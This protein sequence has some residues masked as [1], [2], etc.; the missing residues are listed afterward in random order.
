MIGKVRYKKGLL[1]IAGGEA[2]AKQICEDKFIRSFTLEIKRLW[3]TYLQKHNL[4]HLFTENF[5]AKKS[6]TGEYVFTG[7]SSEYTSNKDQFLLYFKVERQ[8]LEVM[9]SYMESK[10]ANLFLEHDGFRS[11]YQLN[12]AEIKELEDL[13]FS[14]TSVQVKLEENKQEQSISTSNQPSTTSSSTGIGCTN[15]TVFDNSP[16]G[17][18]M[19]AKAEQIER[20]KQLAQLEINTK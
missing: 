9:K 14:R 11:S 13:I 18:A 6:I 17:I 19:R 20:N 15:F 8:I 12:P 4:K 5:S 7:L 10:G 3:R 2:V 1:K 16:A